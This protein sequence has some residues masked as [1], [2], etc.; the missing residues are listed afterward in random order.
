VP[1]HVL[2]F[3]ALATVIILIPGPGVLFIIG[4]AISQ[5]R[6]A[7]LQTVV[8]HAA[9]VY[10]QVV[11]VSLGV[12]AVIAASAAALAVIRLG[13]AAYLVWLGIQ[14]IRRRRESTRS[15][16]RQQHGVGRVLRDAFL[17]GVTN[18]KA[19]VFFIAILPQF[20]DRGAGHAGVQ[21]LLLGLVFVAIALVSDSLWALAA[22][23]A[24]AWFSSSPRRLERL[25]ASGGAMLIGLGAYVAF[26]RRS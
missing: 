9:G 1:G 13:G 14:T 11:A 21:M 17:V 20:V 2:A 16:E 19:I 22:S 7:A 18:A 24:R 8:G 26:G 6:A 3:A 23:R 10:V 15:P 4:R 12:G 5:G 25:T